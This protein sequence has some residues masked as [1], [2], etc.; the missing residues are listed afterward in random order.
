MG[1]RT[2]RLFLTVS[3]VLLA[4]PAVRSQVF[5][6]GMKTATEDVVT[7]FHPTHIEFQTSRWTR[8]AGW[9]S[10]GTSRQSKGSRIVNCR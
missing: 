7:E 6:V 4:A 2:L 5:V 9:S 8:R 10:I 3:C 1:P